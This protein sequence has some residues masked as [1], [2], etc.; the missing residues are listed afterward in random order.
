MNKTMPELNLAPPGEAVKTVIEAPRGWQ[1]INLRELWQYRELLFFLA[2]RDIQVR[3]KQTV[4]GATWAVL[5]PFMT[6]VIFSLIF[7]SF[8]KIPSDGLPY[9]VFIYSALIPWTFFASALSRSANSLVYDANLISKV[10]FPRLL[11]PI[12]AVLSQ[13]V[14]F[15]VAFLVLLGLMAFFGIL[16]GIAVVAL[17][18]FI[19]LAFLTAL[20]VGLWLSA[21]NVKYRDVGYIIPFLTQFWFFITPVSYPISVIPQRWLFLYSLNPMVGV[22]EGF[23]WALLGQ[24]S[25][26]GSVIFISSAVVLLVFIGGLFYFRR[27]EV[28]FADVV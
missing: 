6:M 17:P 7:G 23:R 9:P 16:P 2:W 1:A 14:D 20:G 24:G 4:F 21:L 15:A 25:L 18:V 22:I 3:Y 19:L 27:R 12:A 5:Q 11:L 28:Q 10:Y 26:P 8:L 13:L